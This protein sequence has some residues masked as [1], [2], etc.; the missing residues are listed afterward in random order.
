MH[1]RSSCSSNLDFTTSREHM[2]QTTG[3]CSQA[4]S[5][6]SIRAFAM[7]WLQPW[8]LQVTSRNLHSSGCY[9]SIVYLTLA[10]QPFWKLKHLNSIFSRRPRTDLCAFLMYPLVQRRGHL[11]LAR[12]RHSEQNVFSHS[13]QSFG[14]L[15]TF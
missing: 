10:A 2:L 15:S 12:A 11:L 7:V 4:L 5:W 3:P 9:S 14:S 6:S 1:S 8:Y 13:V